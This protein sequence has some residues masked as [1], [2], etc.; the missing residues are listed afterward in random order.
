MSTDNAPRTKLTKQQN[1]LVQSVKQRF[2]EEFYRYLLKEA[3]GVESSRELNDYSLDNFMTE[4]KRHGFKITSRGNFGL[5]RGM[6]TPRQLAM[7]RKLWAE[8]STENSESA[9]N[10][11]VERFGV[12]ALRFL[13]SEGAHK[14]IT[15]LRAMVAKKQRKEAASREAGDAAAQN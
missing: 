3:A 5:R 12:S 14:T 2:G 13:S 11:F 8:W 1:R 4:A 6:A 15:A 10:H 9:L 7:I